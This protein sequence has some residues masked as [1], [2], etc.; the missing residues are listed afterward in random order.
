MFS[1]DFPDKCEWY[2]E[3]FNAGNNLQINEYWT[4]AKFKKVVSELGVF[5]E[6][7]SWYTYVIYDKD[8]NTMHTN[9]YYVVIHCWMFV[10]P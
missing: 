3:V 10:S 6:Q 4:I 9:V 7:T 2:N 1:V 8:I 5:Y